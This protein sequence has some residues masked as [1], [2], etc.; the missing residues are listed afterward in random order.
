MVSDAIK[1]YFTL[2]SFFILI[3]SA[4]LFGVTSQIVPLEYAKKVEPELTCE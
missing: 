3:G 1:K 4:L 2:S